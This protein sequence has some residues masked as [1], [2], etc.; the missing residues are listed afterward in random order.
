VRDRLREQFQHHG[1][2]DS[3]GRGNRLLGGGGAGGRRHRDAVGGEQFLG[4]DLRQQRAAGG[5]GGGHKG[6]HFLLVG[7]PVLGQGGGRLREQLRAAAVLHHVQEGADGGLGRVERRDVRLVVDRLAGADFL[8]AHPRGQ[9][10]LVLQAGERHEL[11]G[12][13][14]RVG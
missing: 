14:G 6:P 2:A 9:K 5:A 8:S 4:L 13:L 11:A 7:G 3:R 1:V 10:G 12:R